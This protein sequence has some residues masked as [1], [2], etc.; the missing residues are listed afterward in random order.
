MISCN[1]HANV[2]YKAF[3]CS[4]V[5]CINYLPLQLDSQVF[6][7]KSGSHVL[8]KYLLNWIESSLA[9]PSF[10][11]NI[12][13]YQLFLGIIPRM[14]PII[15]IPLSFSWFQLLIVVLLCFTT[16]PLQT[17]VSGFCVCTS[18]ARFPVVPVLLSSFCSRDFMTL[19]YDCL[20][21]WLFVFDQTWLIKYYFINVLH[22]LSFRMLF[23]MLT[24]AFTKSTRS[25]M[26]H[27]FLVTCPHLDFSFTFNYLHMVLK[28]FLLCQI[29]NIQKSRKN[30]IMNSL[31]PLPSF[32]SN[33]LT[34]S[35]VYKVCPE[36]IQPHTMKNRD[37]YWRRYKVQETLL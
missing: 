21:D 16:Y 2:Y 13:Y 22:R 34:N 30:D 8:G 25:C 28:S 15:S 20:L 4:R 32:N 5:N 27:L 23:F 24:W 35:L 19:L 26:W 12:K 29:L 18:W 7:T 33:E 11:L 17:E 37:I 14:Y 31:Y 36:S 3:I 10:P 1:F 6:E 9:P